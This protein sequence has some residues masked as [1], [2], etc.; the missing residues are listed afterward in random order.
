MPSSGLTRERQTAARAMSPP[1]LPFAGPGFCPRG[2]DCERGLAENRRIRIYV[3]S[4]SGEAAADGKGTLEQWTF[5]HRFLKGFPRFCGHS[6]A[7][8]LAR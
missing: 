8:T 1:W 7:G 2:L 5:D 6:R 4:A 3:V